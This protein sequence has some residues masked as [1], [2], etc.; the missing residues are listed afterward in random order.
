V[1][2]TPHLSVMGSRRT[3]VTGPDLGRLE[4]VVAPQVLEAM[5][6]ASVAL[7]SIGVRHSIAGGLAVGAHGFER[8]TKDVDFL[9]GYEAFEH[10]AGGIVTLKPGVPIQVGGVLID[11][12]SIGA[13]E[14]HLETALKEPVLP[15]TALVYLKLKSPRAKDRSDLVE[16]VKRWEDV[17]DVRAYIAAVRPDFMAKLEEI[18]RTARAEED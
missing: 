7:T 16:L 8:A 13:D 18:V 17:E 6:Q 9:V 2:N 15:R 11:V 12:L 5:R 4:G 14:R 10:H 1:L 3:S